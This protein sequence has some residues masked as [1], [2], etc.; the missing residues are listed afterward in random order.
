VLSGLHLHDILPED[1]S[2]PEL[3]EQGELGLSISWALYIQHVPQDCEPGQ[4]R[5]WQRHLCQ[6]GKWVMLIWPLGDA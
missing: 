5:L 1:S 4:T 2:L 6:R 3:P